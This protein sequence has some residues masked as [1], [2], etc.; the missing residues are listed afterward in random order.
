MAGCLVV[1][2]AIDLWFFIPLFSKRWKGRPSTSKQPRLDRTAAAFILIVALLQHGAWAA[3]NQNPQTPT[4]LPQIAGM[5]LVQIALVPF[6]YSQSYLLWLT[7]AMLNSKAPQLNHQRLLPQSRPGHPGLL[8]VTA[9]MPCRNEPYDV[10]RMTVESLLNLVYPDGYLNI[11][12]ADNSDTE[13][14]DAER[15]REWINAASKPSR[16]IHFLH[17]DGTKNFKAGNLDLAMAQVRSELVLLVDVD[18]TV[19]SQL[20]LDSTACFLNSPRLGFL[21]F[22]NIPTNSPM[23]KAAAIAA[24][25]LLTV[26][27]KEYH[28]AELGGWCFF[29]GHNA[30]WRTEALKCIGPLSQ[31]LWGES[32]L[33]EDV[34]MSIR[35]NRA[36]FQGQMHFIPTGFWAPVSLRGL[37]RMLSR[38][39]YGNLQF[40]AKESSFLLNG[41]HQTLSP[42]ERMDLLF[43]F[44]E[45][46]LQALFPFALLIIP[47]TAPALIMLYCS[48]L[49]T[50]LITI[51]I[52]FKCQDLQPLTHRPPW[53]VITGYLLLLPFSYG[54]S[55]KAM[56]EFLSRKQQRW[57]PTDKT[58]QTRQDQPRWRSVG[59]GLRAPWL[60]L[61]A[62]LIAASLLLLQPHTRLDSWLRLLPLLLGSIM[63][64]I[65]IAREGLPQH[66]I[67]TELAASEASN[68]LTSQS[69]TK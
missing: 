4:D 44:S 57:I 46:F 68:N 66:A 15:L 18:S 34:A 39:S 45:T 8:S 42:S 16:A 53:Y 3:L 17:R 29:Q 64:L 25:M 51:A 56:V 27:I 24:S 2:S 50:L 31:R 10:A 14:R 13:H 26:K 62:I 67:A 63:V 41:D 43:H 9:I 7:A 60:A 48:F 58:Y 32:L 35:A 30:L 22:F 21:Q 12:I 1:V 55:L 38:W 19:P 11:I 20:L 40:L 33:A 23:G 49:P 47:A 6:F 59:I 37:Q 54:C 65:V 69:P 61:A 5:A 52:Y 36:G 28:Q